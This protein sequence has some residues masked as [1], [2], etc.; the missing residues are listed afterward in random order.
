MKFLSS[1]ATGVLVFFVVLALPSRV[2]AQQ[3]IGSH[4]GEGDPTFQ[5]N[6][7]S[8]LA[9]NGAGSGFPVTIQVSIDT[10]DSTIASLAS[11]ASSHGF[12]PIVRINN[13]CGKIDPVSTINSINNHFGSDVTIVFGNEL[14]HTDVECPG[15]I[16]G[17]LQYRINYLKIAA[18]NVSPAPIDWYAPDAPSLGVVSANTLL[19]VLGNIFNLANLRA[20][21]SY[22]CEG[23]TAESCDPLTTDS[24]NKGTTGV[25][26]NFVQT[27]FSL[28][29]PGSDDSPDTDLVK[30]VKFIEKRGPETGA[31]KITPLIRNVCNDDGDWL[32][33]LGGNGEESARILTR[34]G[35][36]I[37]IETCSA[38]E[39]DKHHLR[40]PKNLTLS[41]FEQIF[42]TAQENALQLTEVLTRD[43][44]SAQ[45]AAPE[46]RVGPE[47]S[48]PLDVWEALNPDGVID[49]FPEAESDWGFSNA[50]QPSVRRGTPNNSALGSV[51]QNISYINSDTTH[52][53]QEKIDDAPIYSLSPSSY[54]VSLQ[55]DHLLFIEDACDDLVT[56][57]NSDKIIKGTSFKPLELLQVVRSH[58]GTAQDIA[59]GKLGDNMSKEGFEE[60]RFA[61][62]RVPLS[63]INTD[64]YAWIVVSIEQIKNKNS[65]QLFPVKLIQEKGLFNF[66]ASLFEGP[67]SRHRVAARL[68]KI[69]DVNTDQSIDET[70]FRQPAQIVSNTQIPYKLAN[71]YRDLTREAIDRTTADSLAQGR[72][73]IIS[74]SI[75]RIVGEDSKDPLTRA[76]TNIINGNAPNC[77]Q[78][79]I[80]AERGSLISFPAKLSTQ[81]E[82]QQE[83]VDG[84]SVP[85]GL[86]SS[87]SE[88][89][90]LFQGIS[91]KFKSSV[92]LRANEI[93][94]DEARVNI[95]LVSP[96]SSLPNE[97]ENTYGGAFLTHEDITIFKEL[98]EEGGV[99]SYYE[100]NQVDWDN[101]DTPDSF[102][103]EDPNG[104]CTTDPITNEV[105]CLSTVSVST[106]L[107]TR[108]LA[109][110][111]AGSDNI[112]TRYPSRAIY[113]YNSPPQICAAQST[114]N[115]QF[116]TCTE[117]SSGSGDNTGGTPTLCSTYD[118]VEIQILSVADTE[119]LIR[120]KAAK[121]ST[122]PNLP[123]LL[124]GVYIIEGSRYYTPQRAGVS[125]I[126]CADTINPCGAVG[127]MQIIHGICTTDCRGNADL[128]AFLKKLVAPERT[129]DFCSIEGS[130]D[131]AAKEL[132]SHLKTRN[133]YQAA[134]AY[135][136]IDQEYPGPKCEGAPA[137]SGCVDDNG[138]TYNYCE[139]AVDLFN[140]GSSTTPL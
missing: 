60:M 76:L 132:A 23:E 6:I 56:V 139:C 49:L 16:V 32:I 79:K 85:L 72:L 63:L 94:T 22:G 74:Q 54:L 46:F 58:G 35:A 98:L 120:E 105:S 106:R 112:I 114:T 99:S 34:N 48:G 95:Y 8:M 9:S 51:E 47:Y 21:N 111:G 90:N 128:T 41:I 130:L 136:G 12:F 62:S 118:S 81:S 119:N 7:M 1:L 107:K 140:L 134:G 77:E 17:W 36:E 131:W 137:V 71:K 43:G 10:G 37:D 69:A 126:S 93:D 70:Y 124:F 75:I 30:V 80:E 73:P 87:F 29:P 122:D 19:Q 92:T 103:F 68:I 96:N 3:L 27:E 115:E 108:P 117:G 101:T 18:A 102:E 44:Y 78:D 82:D 2:Q 40:K 116:L 88:I 5:I 25:G 86:F 97:L 57:C 110:R 15:G 127:P 55:I 123:N 38:T 20:T 104:V 64:R 84:L 39:D 31:E 138:K 33:Y 65:T 89:G 66:L 133:P 109:I 42:N 26:G 100:F 28:F 59:D 14:N 113:P 4:L 53:S 50:S 83:H 67:V 24:H 129:G 45:C 52:P 121:Y 91:Y 11:A 13:A 135:H 125:S 61:L